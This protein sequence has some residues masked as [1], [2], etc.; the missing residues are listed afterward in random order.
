MVSTVQRVLCGTLLALF[1]CLGG[2]SPAG[3]Y[4]AAYEV[5]LDRAYRT[6]D[7]VF[8]RTR[9]S[10]LR[11]DGPGIDLGHWLPVR[12]DADLVA[13]AMLRYRAEYPED[14]VD[15]GELRRSLES[16]EIKPLAATRIATVTVRAGSRSLSERLAGTAAR[17]LAEHVSER[18]SAEI[19][20][21]L[22]DVRAAL[23]QA[24][25]DVEES[26]RLISDLAVKC[27]RVRLKT[28]MGAGPRMTADMDVA[29]G[30][31]RFV[32]TAEYAEACRRH[33]E[34]LEPAYEKLLSDERRASRER[35]LDRPVA[36]VLGPGGD[37]SP[38]A[39]NSAPSACGALTP[40]ERLVEAERLALADADFRR[41]EG[42][43]GPGMVR[44]RAESPHRIYLYMG[45]AGSYSRY[46]EGDF[47]RL[48]SSMDTNSAL[49]GFLG[50]RF[51]EQAKERENYVRLPEPFEG[52]A[53]V[54]HQAVGG[55]MKLARCDSRMSFRTHGLS[56]APLRRMARVR[57]RFEREYGVDFAEMRRGEDYFAGG[58]VNGGWRVGLFVTNALVKA[59]SELLV[60]YTMGF[61]VVNEIVLPPWSETGPD[62]DDCN[63][64]DFLHVAEIPRSDREDLG[65]WEYRAPRGKSTEDLLD[66]F[67]RTGNR[68]ILKVGRGVAGTPV[69]WGG[70]AAASGYFAGQGSPANMGY[71]CA[72]WEADLVMPHDATFVKLCDKE[73]K[74]RLSAKLYQSEW[75]RPREKGKTGDFTVGSIF[76]ELIPGDR[77]T[78]YRPDCRKKGTVCGE[79]EEGEYW[80]CIHRKMKDV[81]TVEAAREEDW[82]PT[83]L[84]REME[85]RSDEV[86]LRYWRVRHRA[87]PRRVPGRSGGWEVRPLDLASTNLVAATN[88]LADCL[89]WR[90]PGI[91]RAPF[92]EHILEMEYRSREFARRKVRH[93]E[94]VAV[95][96]FQYKLFN[97]RR[98]LLEEY[99]PE[100]FFTNGVPDDESRVFSLSRFERELLR[101]GREDRQTL[102]PRMHPNSF[103]VVPHR[104][105]DA[106]PRV[107]SGNEVEALGKRLDAC[108][109]RLV[110]FSREGGDGRL[111]TEGE[112]IALAVYEVLQSAFASREGCAAV[113]E[114]LPRCRTLVAANLRKEPMS[115]LVRRLV[116]EFRESAEAWRFAESIPPEVERLEKT[117]FAD[118]RAE[119]GT[120][121]AGWLSD[122]RRIL[123]R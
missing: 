65:R 114:L 100:G 10:Y 95:E 96:R 38:S 115:Y 98:R 44:R 109:D 105:F 21:D 1:A 32:Q 122:Y 11:D 123:G 67:I 15:D 71:Q 25:S 94:N 40:R 19:S 108:A 84:T 120:S 62:G 89:S 56:P 8:P 12:P 113:R 47:S 20:R 97:V 33:S 13:K 111:L 46:C 52:F 3:G 31:T 91:Y 41:R 68:D 16:A 58:Y 73:T 80:D 39:T 61:D 107:P 50:C 74:A 101:L 27:G 22:A 82:S 17:A 69:G 49:M 99:F 79:H 87:D 93:R 118:R 18:A 88:L 59:G 117:T 106:P 110:D 4:A 9:E 57:E 48:N 30:R 104:A 76:W 63:W 75:F 2:C 90:R 36:C 103:V 81:E 77:V 78:W 7:A 70:G 116:M 43:E 60:E 119:A 51:G 64:R 24:K 26:R 112:D 121:L 85:K 5:A 45:P 66:E 35:G 28:T 83:G 29:S 6:C 53:W 34:K 86:D 23:A 37:V 42:K 92:M 102:F 72:E 55:G 14:G 54:R